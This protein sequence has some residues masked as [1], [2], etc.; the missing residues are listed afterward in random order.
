[1]QKFSLD[2]EALGDYQLIR[3]LDLLKGWKILKSLERPA[4]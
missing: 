4:A 2:E 1:V 3:A